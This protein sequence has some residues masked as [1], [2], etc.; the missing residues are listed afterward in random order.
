MWRGLETEL[1]SFLN[2]HEG[3]NPGYSQEGGRYGLLRQ[4]STYRDNFCPPNA[5]FLETI[6]AIEGNRPTLRSMAHDLPLH[7]RAPTNEPSICLMGISMANTGK[8][9]SREAAAM[10]IRDCLPMGTGRMFATDS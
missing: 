3:G 1:R 2:E 10:G 5:R 6:A 8:I 9:G 7:K 4:R